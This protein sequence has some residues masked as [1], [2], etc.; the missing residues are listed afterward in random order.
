MRIAVLQATSAVG[1]VDANLDI[2]TA[3]AG[4]AA[5]GGADIL[6][7]PELFPTGYAPARI[8][9]LDGAPVRQAVSQL[10]ER[11]GI[12]VVAST[13]EQADSGRFITATLF[14]SDGTQV[15]HYRK[16]HLF[17]TEEQ[18]FTAGTELSRI[19]RFGD[20]TV[21]LGICYDVE[22]PEYVRAL[23]VGGA[24]LVLVPTAVPTRVSS[25]FD[26]AAVPGLLVPA[27]ALENTVAIAYAN[28]C[29]TGF[30][31]RSCIVAPDG[32]IA[33]QTEGGAKLIFADITSETIRGARV[34]NPYLR[35]RR[36]DLY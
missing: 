35:S 36:L 4:D 32:S 2:L 10:A 7:T 33:A 28:Q 25:T 22:F 6:V 30:A 3:A 5:D 8:H 11:S 1:H 9:H 31:G 18:F 17:G 23:A 29:G 34:D 24:D 16:S 14:G 20:L 13:V 19:V 26:A 21:A 15:L 12:A 27:R